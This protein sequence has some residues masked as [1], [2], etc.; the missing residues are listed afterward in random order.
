VLRVEE[1]HPWAER[2]ADAG[3]RGRAEHDDR[4]ARAAGWRGQNVAAIAPIEA[5]IIAER[6]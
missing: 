1:R 4:A 2:E 5:G 3:A 6:P